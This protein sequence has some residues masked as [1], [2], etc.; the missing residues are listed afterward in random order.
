MTTSEGS[1]RSSIPSVP[2]NYTCNK[3]QKIGKSSIPRFMVNYSKHAKNGKPHIDAT[4]Y[5]NFKKDK[6][7]YS[8]TNYSEPLKSKNFLRKPIKK[9]ESLLS[10]IQ[11]KSRQKVVTSLLGKSKIPVPISAKK[12][13]VSTPSTLIS[14]LISTKKA[15]RVSHRNCTSPAKTFNTVIN[16]V[17]T[18]KR[19][20][21]RVLRSN[22][23]KVN[24]DDSIKNDVTPSCNSPSI[25][26]KKSLIPVRKLSQNLFRKRVSP[27]QP[28]PST[29]KRDD[30]SSSTPALIKR[31]ELSPTPTLIKRD[32]MSPTPPFKR[33]EMSPTPTL[34]KRDALSPSPLKRDE[35]S[36]TP[37][38]L[39]SFS[40]SNKEINDLECCSLQ[41][42]INVEVSTTSSIS[43]P[44]TPTCDELSSTS[45]ETN[46]LEQKS[47]DVEISA[48]SSISL[49]STPTCDELSSTSTSN[50]ETNDL[51]Q[52]SVEME[53]S[54]ASSVSLP[55]TPTC[56]ELSSTSTETND[57]EQKSIDVEISATSSVSLPSTPTYDELSSTSTSNKE[58]NDLE[59]KSIDIEISAASSVS[60]PST[61]TCDELSSTSTKTNDL[62]QKS[63]DVEISTT[64]SISL[65][66]TPTYDELSST[67]T[68][69]KEANDLICFSLKNT[70]AYLQKSVNKPEASISITHNVEVSATI[71]KPELS[72]ISLLHKAEKNLPDIGDKNGEVAPKLF[73][74][75]YKRFNKFISKN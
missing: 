16:T 57:L 46:D 27:S 29:P 22:R 62:E 31:D 50:K 13:T 25:S 53:I 75:V 67:S 9:V 17:N 70:H 19:K 64:S 61:P 48:T 54:T 14:T 65:P 40:T 10:S 3:Q 63:I 58:T 2:I 7:S 33:D 66:S 12:A 43:L 11:E 24:Q 34:F 6:I 45:T 44:S 26:A 56:D 41:K 20:T 4:E 15:T 73:T 38:G 59:Q 74:N 28:Q 35:L 51:E 30:L 71:I 68:S 1:K 21:S 36:P 37:P 18:V 55:S 72:P 32:E 8:S 42:S 60:L 49:P 23:I 69:H 52:K 39:S 47:I 5:Y